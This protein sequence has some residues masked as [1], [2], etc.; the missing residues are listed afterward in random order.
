MLSSQLINAYGWRNTFIIL[1][2]I[3]LVVVPPLAQFLRRDPSQKGLSP[4]GATEQADDINNS[5]D[6]G[7]TLGEALRNKQYWTVCIVF[8]I[9][10]YCANSLM[11]HIVPYATGIGISPVRAAS[12]MSIIGGVSII[13]RLAV[14]SAGDRMGN[15]RTMTF[16]FISL[17][18]SVL[19]LLPATQLWQLYLFAVAYGFTHGGF[20]TLIS[21]LIADLF[22][23]KAHG[24][25]FGFSS[26][27]STIGG[28]IGPLIAGRIFD[29]SGSYS[30][31]FWI[32]IGFAGVGLLLSLLLKPI[33]KQTPHKYGIS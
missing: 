25:L 11:L 18:I 5:L 9:M 32:V 3:C 13:G 20:F 1:G 8:F 2:V 24:T 7:I 31:V 30:L 22:G 10:W 17:I 23:T 27:I 21:P 14:G 19:W 15:I 26:F 6:G 28:A 16:C 12:L 29:V 4:Y 33:E